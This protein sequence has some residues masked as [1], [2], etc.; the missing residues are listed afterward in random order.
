MARSLQQQVNLVHNRGVGYPAMV[1]HV[2]GTAQFLD[3]N[4]QTVTFSG[5]ETN[6]VLFKTDRKSVV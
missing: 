2:T 4:T 1:N 6:V 3:P 5:A